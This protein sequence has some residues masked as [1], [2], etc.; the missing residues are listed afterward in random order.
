MP[1]NRQARSRELPSAVEGLV[2]QSASSLLPRIDCQTNSAC[3]AFP[4]SSPTSPT[5]HSPFL[6]KFHFSFLGAQNSGTSGTSAAEWLSG[7]RLTPCRVPYF[8]AQS[9]ALI[10]SMQNSDGPRYRQRDDQQIAVLGWQNVRDL[11]PMRIDLKCEIH[12]RIAAAGEFSHLVGTSPSKRPSLRKP[13]S[14][15]PR[16]CR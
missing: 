11:L 15:R 3:S 5:N 2:R 6:W 8:A 9:V 4:S 13:S 12:S 1:F 10:F 7:R 14:G 16:D